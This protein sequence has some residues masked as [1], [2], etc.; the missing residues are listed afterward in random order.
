[1]TS[2]RLLSE[3]RRDEGGYILTLTALLMVP[4]LIVAGLAVDFGGWYTEASHMQRAADAAAL[5]GVVWLPDMTTATSTALASAK[6]NGFDDAA[7]NITV[8]VTQ[9]GVSRLG[10]SIT[11][12]GGQVYL[13]KFVKN[14]VTIT[15]S[16]TAEYNLPIPLGSPKNYFGTGNMIS[17]ANMENFY[18]AINGNCWDKNQGDPFA[19]KYAGASGGS[20]CPGG[21][22]NPQ[23][24]ASPN[25]QYQYYVDVPAGRSSPI[26]LHIW[27]PEGPS[28]DNTIGTRT[29]PPT[30]GPTFDPGGCIYG[31]T[32]NITTT[33]TLR[34]P[35]T[36]PLNDADNPAV[37]CNGAT[38]QSYT[39]AASLGTVDTLLGRYGWVRFCTI[40]TTWAPGTYI[41]DVRNAPNETGSNGANGYSVM[42]DYNGAGATCDSRTDPTCPAV[43]GKD[44]ISILAT[45]SSSSASFYLANIGPLNGGKTLQVTMYDPGEGGQDIRLLKPDGTQA[46]FDWQDMGTDDAT[47]GAS[48]T[49]AVLLDVTGSKFNGHYVQLTTTLPSNYATLYS[50]FWW[51]ILYN[52]GS[53][54]VTD[55]TTW[56]VKMLGTPVHLV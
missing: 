10:V 9:I 8:S 22:L 48:A 2:G 54:A 41:F 55:R 24:I 33:F 11:D 53:G 50:Q 43:Y 6:Q 12:T 23:Y 20:S 18:A 40:P 5:A 17:G 4:L 15:R 46:T 34:A 27:D 13:A 49:G 35:D 39:T 37:T 47:P 42:A 44:W 7:S 1:M 32:T 56:G 26:T 30:A 36:T 38:S 45:S 19:V 3:R 29:C 31:K 16:A 52:F 25:P 28:V 51:K 14:S 21:T